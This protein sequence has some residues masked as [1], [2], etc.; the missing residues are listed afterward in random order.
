MKSKYQIYHAIITPVNGI[1]RKKDMK[2]INKY[3]SPHN[4]YIIKSSGDLKQ[5]ENS[6]K[7]TSVEK[8]YLILIITDTQLS[9]VKNHKFQDVATNKQI[10]ESFFIG[11]WKMILQLIRKPKSKKIIAFI[12]KNKDGLFYAF[13]KPSQAGGY[14]AFNVKTIQE[15]YKKINEN[16]V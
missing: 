1:V 16:L 2:K 8:E 13:G 15:A 11:D 6:L 14:I 5:L 3:V 4:S 9:K 10:S 12:G 7:N